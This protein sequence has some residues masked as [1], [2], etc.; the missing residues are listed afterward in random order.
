LNAGG[1]VSFSFE[2]DPLRFE[3][4]LTAA[5]DAHLKLSS[6]LLALAR[7]VVSKAEL[8]HS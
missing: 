6:R 4:S 5:G 3:M 7:R 1:I 2:Q 8:G